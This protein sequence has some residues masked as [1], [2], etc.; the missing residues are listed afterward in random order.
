MV[1]ITLKNVSK[2]FGTQDV[3]KGI[4]LNCPNGKITVI[5]GQSGVGKTVLLKHMIGLLKP[6]NGK[7]FVGAHDITKLGPIE[8][9]DLRKS[10][11]YLFHDA[12]LFDD[13]TVF[14]NVSFPIRE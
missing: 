5:L 12:A 7:I 3:L 4:D 13:M 6:D 14:E 9:K 2:R 10:F 1:E 11:G 8:L